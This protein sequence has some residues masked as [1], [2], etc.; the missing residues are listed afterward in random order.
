MTGLN[1]L[2][3]DDSTEDVFFQKAALKR[4]AP[5]ANV[6]SCAYAHEA[7]DYL[8]DFNHP[9]VDVIFLDIALPRMTGF[10]FLDAYAKRSAKL[11]ERHRI[12]MVSA[13][14]DP[15]DVERAHDHPLVSD[16]MRKP[17]TQD[18]FA[19]IVQR[20]RAEKQTAAT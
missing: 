19:A 13:S 15:A 20:I 7:L 16:F 3:V 8:D 12:V 14:I 2:F 6:V 18:L 17:L 4:V 5:D 11:R 1:V 10:E 9:E